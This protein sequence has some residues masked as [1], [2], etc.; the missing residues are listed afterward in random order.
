MN[1]VYGNPGE[2]KE[3]SFQS[4]HV[5]GIN[6][7]LIKKNLSQN[8]FQKLGLILRIDKGQITPMKNLE[9]DISRVSLLQS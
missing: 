5:V 7:V 9:N 2:S 6:L 4:V 8:F 1:A 3:L